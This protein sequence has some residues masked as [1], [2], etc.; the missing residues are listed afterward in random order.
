MEPKTPKAREKNSP[1]ANPVMSNCPFC[2]PDES[3]SLD[4]K[5]A[6]PDKPG[7]ARRLGRGLQWL[8]PAA[9]LALMPKCP[10]CVVAYFA[11]FTGVGISVSTARWLQVLMLLLCLGSFSYLAVRLLRRRTSGISS[12]DTAAARPR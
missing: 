3:Q 10:L 2:N 9:L 7:L 8:F 12:C 6:A 11:L 4:Q 1:R 5:T